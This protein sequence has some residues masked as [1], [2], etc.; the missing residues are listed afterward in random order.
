MQILKHPGPI[1]VIIFIYPLSTIQTLK[2]VQYTKCNTMNNL[3]KEIS[4]LLS[5][6]P[7]QYNEVNALRILGD[8]TNLWVLN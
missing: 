1:E 7:M 8:C 6:K 2:L 4:T 5:L 3:V